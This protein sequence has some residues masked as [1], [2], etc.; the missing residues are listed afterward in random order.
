M[1]LGSDRDSQVG[2]LIPVCEEQKEAVLSCYSH[3]TKNT[4]NCLS[5]V[6]EYAQC[7]EKARKVLY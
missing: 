6:H 1:L 3:N 7:V 4:L 5:E 2:Q